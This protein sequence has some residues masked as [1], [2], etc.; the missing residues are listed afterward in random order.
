N[1]GFI[2]DGKIIIEARFTLNKIIGIRTA[3]RVD[4]TDPNE[5]RHDVALVIDGKKIYVR[6]HILG[7]HSPVF[8]AMFY[9]NFDEK[10]KKEM[11]LKDVNRDEFIEMLN[12]IY[13][14]NAMITGL[15]N[16]PNFLNIFLF[17][18]AIAEYL[19]KLGDQYQIK[20]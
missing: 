3:P 5:P 11:E 10:D 4:F 15:H 7:F 19:L 17:I 18:D 8:N 12:V 1:Q 14:S 9:G 2:N 16:F 20:V 13:P 6:K